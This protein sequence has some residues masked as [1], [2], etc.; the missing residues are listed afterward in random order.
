M[1]SKTYLQAYCQVH[2]KTLGRSSFP[3]WIIA[4]GGVVGWG[5]ASPFAF[6]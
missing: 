5:T 4:G 3:N 1:R 2:M 6:V